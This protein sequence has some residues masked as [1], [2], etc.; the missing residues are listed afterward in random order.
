MKSKILLLLLFMCLGVNINAFA[1][2]SNIDE[3]MLTKMCVE[4]NDIDFDLD[5]DGYIIILQ[6]QENNITIVP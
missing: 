2:E 6:I 5:I 4:N 1:Y 3:K